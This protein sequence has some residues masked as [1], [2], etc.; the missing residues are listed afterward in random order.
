MAKS[1]DKND[2]G[3]RGLIF[4]EDKF[5]QESSL[6]SHYTKIRDVSIKTGYWG[7]QNPGLDLP[8]FICYSPASFADRLWELDRR[9]LHLCFP[10]GLCPSGALLETA[11]APRWFS[12]RCL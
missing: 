3:L 10:D 11:V 6:N 9:P 4:S 7:G 12:V 2:R 5:S 1:F 8:Q